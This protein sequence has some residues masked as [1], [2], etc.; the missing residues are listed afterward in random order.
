MRGPFLEGT[1]RLRQASVST[2][3]GVGHAKK[4]V[5]PLWR[6]QRDREELLTEGETGAWSCG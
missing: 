1:D 2:Q 3:I 5:H 4:G 6:V